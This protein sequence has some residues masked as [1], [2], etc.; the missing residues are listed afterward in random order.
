MPATFD[1]FFQVATGK[2]Q[3]YGYQCR[4]AC[5]P[6]AKVD[7]P[8]TLKSG[9]IC[10]SK[11]ISIP[12]GLG[13]TAAVLLAWLWNR[14][15]RGDESW[16]R[17]LVYCLPMRTLVEQTAGE[18]ENCFENLRQNADALDLSSEVREQ[19]DWLAIHSPVILMGGED[20]GEWEIHPE[21]PAIL[22]GTQDMLLSRALNRG[23]GA[24]RARWPMH[25]GLLNNDTLW[26]MDETQLMGPGLGTAC[27]LEAFRTGSTLGF[28]SFGTGGSATWYMSA[29]N[30]PEHLKTR[31]WRGVARPDAFEFGLSSE[32]KAATTGPIHQRRFAVKRM[33]LE[34]ASS[35]ENL[36]AAK[37][38]VATILPHHEAML[39]AIGSDTT[40]PA[41]TLIICNTVDRA[42]D[43]HR[44]L[45]TAK[46][47]GCDLL[48]LHSRFRPPERR[49]QMERLKGASLARFPKGQIVVS[50]Q[51][52]EAGV[53]ISS[54]V[55]FSEVAPLASLVQ[56]LGRLNRAGEFNKSAWKPAAYVV[57]V[58][59]ESDSAGKNDKARQEIR[60]NN[61]GRCLPYELSACESAWISL[62]KLNEDASPANLERIQ[63]DIAASIPRCSYSLQR[64]ELTD[65]F[66][67]DANLSLGFTDVSPF[68]RGLD[69][70]TDLQVCWREP[71]SDGDGQPDFASDYQRDELCSVPIGKT[72][73]AREVLNHGWLWR[74]KESGWVS[75]RDIQPAP[76]MTI[77]L[78]LSAGGYENTAGWTGDKADNKHS[79][80]YQSKDGPSDEEQLSSLANGWQSIAIHTAEVAG[81]LRELLG[82]LLTSKE[83]DSE[84]HALLSAVPWH[85]I[86]KNHPDWQQAVLAALEK[87]GIAG[88]EAHLPFAK[89]SLSESPSLSENGQRLEGHAR[90]KKIRELKNLFRPGVAH[91][92]VSALAFRQAEQARLGSARDTD[93]ASLLAEYVIM[94]HHGR[95]RKVLRDEIPKFPKDEKDTEKVRGV[96][97]DDALPEVI[98]D[99]KKL[100]CDSLSTDCR[101]MGRDTN[102]R[103]SYT[104]SVLR[105]LDHYGPFRLAFFEAIFRAADIRASIAASKNHKA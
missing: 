74:G 75:M 31:E 43:V 76:G 26:V 32:E 22:I 33:K 18:L 11:L 58:G 61:A 34:D 100:G 48:L 4:L 5:G 92:V 45:S 42:V 103:E 29:T 55:L 102:G 105:L 104:R 60:N 53:D 36:T 2:P 37:S 99:G 52:I 82:Y 7:D 65:F 71:W 59:V 44:Q 64:H 79:S 57:G 46:P 101:R 69:H 77:L 87:A 67:T 83:N 97:H 94:S 70:D 72:L 40:L 91:E 62:R 98:I 95:V 15:V 39:A 38:I 41:R 51:V 84:R 81:E 88:K 19:L 49:E 21:H 80:H 63:A 85:D 13:K 12:T 3:P 73:K 30:N 54:G 14:T 17:R 8:G 28:G 9:A 93:L 78:P 90:K 96:S 23:Y 47:D 89:F 66:D 56:R 27:Q 10:A 16:P 35:F 1:D 20:A 50:T 25:F 86:G 68:V 24:K 6:D